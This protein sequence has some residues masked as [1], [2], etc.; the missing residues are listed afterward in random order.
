MEIIPLKELTLS[1]AMLLFALVS[2]FY[3]LIKGIYNKGTEEQKAINKALSQKDE[4]ITAKL[5]ALN[6]N[7]IKVEASV[8]NLKNKILNDV[9]DDIKDKI[10]RAEHHIEANTQHT[11]NLALEALDKQYN[12]MENKGNKILSEMDS[13][14][15]TLKL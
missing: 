5:T 4:I 9:S 2:L 6:I 15:V 7:I 8:E 13:K 3:S 12:K 14:I 10:K 11:V 1:L